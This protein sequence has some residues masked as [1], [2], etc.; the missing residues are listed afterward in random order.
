MGE[1]YAGCPAGGSAPIPDSVSVSSPV[2]T[3]RA[4]RSAGRRSPLEP[5]SIGLLTPLFKKLCFGFVEIPL[6]RGFVEQSFER[7]EWSGPRGRIRMPCEAVLF[8]LLLRAFESVRVGYPCHVTLP[9]CAKH[10]EQIGAVRARVKPVK[11]QTE[12]LPRRA[13]RPCAG[14]RCSR[15]ARARVSFLRRGQIGKSVPFVRARIASTLTVSN[16]GL[17]V[18]STWPALADWRALRIL[19]VSATAAF[20]VVASTRTD[21]TDWRG[22]NVRKFR[23]STTSALLLSDR[24]R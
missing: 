20:F 8:G 9:L 23:T 10:S 12:T 19:Q 1:S 14:T 13:C 22:A 6:S 15:R 7:L 17:L 16:A 24:R 11:F 5:L 2:M 18:P 21:F 3:A 4:L